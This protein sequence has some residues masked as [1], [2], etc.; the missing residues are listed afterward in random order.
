MKYLLIIA[1]LLF[2]FVACNSHHGTTRTEEI[3]DNN[4]KMK[5]K[6]DG[7]TMSIQLKI[8]NVEMPVD[9]D[10]KFDVKHMSD[11]QK[12][13]LKNHILDSLYKLNK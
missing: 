7:K 13:T 10:E 12:Q 3:N 4:K 11:E 9:Y 2:S 6:D 5:V 1:L 8:R